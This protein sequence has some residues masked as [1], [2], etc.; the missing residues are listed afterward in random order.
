MENMIEITG[1]DLVEF[2]KKV[3]TLSVPQ[4]LGFLHAE[5]GVL[6]DEDAKDIVSRCSGSIALS[7]DYVKGRACKMNVR[8]DENG[9]L[10]IQ[11]SWYDHTDHQLAELLE[12]FAL[13][14]PDPTKHGAACECANC[15]M[16]RQHV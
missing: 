2:A 16:K 4:G 15:M 6:E 8:R 10:W 7:M 1:A 12:H 9:G 5:Q 11:K 13:S 14:A 3:Y